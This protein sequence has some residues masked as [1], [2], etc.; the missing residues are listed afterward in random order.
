[1]LGHGDSFAGIWDT[2]VIDG[3]TWGVPWYVD[4]RGNRVGSVDPE[5]MKIT[6]YP[7]PDP[8]ARPRRIANK[9]DHCVSRPSFIAGI[10]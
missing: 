4:F 3:A 9:C 8:A 1:M 2:N 6:E 10:E 5:T 7:L